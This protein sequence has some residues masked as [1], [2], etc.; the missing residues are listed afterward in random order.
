MDVEYIIKIKGK[1]VPVFKKGWE[2]GEIAR[3]VVT[4]KKVR[5]KDLNTPVL[6]MAIDEH[7]NEVLKKFVE[8]TKKILK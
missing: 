7:G 5:K 6:L 3:V 8:V 2:R 1:K 4:F